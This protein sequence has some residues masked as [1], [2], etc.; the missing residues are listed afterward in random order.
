MWTSL[1]RGL[2]RHEALPSGALWWLAAD[3]M[4]SWYR[5]LRAGL[6]EPLG[7]R[8]E[9]ERVIASVAG[10]VL[11]RRYTALTTTYPSLPTDA[12]AAGLVMGALYLLPIN[13]R[14]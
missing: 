8:P 2:F 3:G 5:M 10:R 6:A 14:L 12:D 1:A 11:A 9:A 4:S 13:A 7:G